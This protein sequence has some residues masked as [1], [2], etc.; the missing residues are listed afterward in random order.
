MVPTSLAL[1]M[2]TYPP[3]KRST[4]IRLWAAVGGVAAALGPVVGGLLVTI[5]WRWVFLINL[6]IGIVTVLVGRR[7]LTKSP[8]RLAGRLPD[9]FGALILLAAIGLLSLGIVK[10]P[11]WGWLSASVF[12]C[13]GVGVALIWVFLLRS[14]HHPSPIVAMHLWRIRSY[15][16]AAVASLLFSVA[17]AAM[18]LSAVLWMQDAWQWSGLLTGFAIAPGPAMLPILAV[19]AAPLARKVGPGVLAAVGSLALAGGVYWWTRSVDVDTSYLTTMLPGI[20]LSGIGV[21]L[22]LPTLISS[23][24]S[25]V[26][27]PW[28]AT[29]SAVITMVRQIGFVLG[30][31]IFIGVLGVPQT[32]VEL[33]SDFVVAWDVTAASAVLAAASSLLMEIWLRRGHQTLGRHRSSR[34]T[35]SATSAKCE[36]CG[37]LRAD[38]S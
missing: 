2:G 1:L 29:G 12:G 33:H 28:F 18:L 5:S 16:A 13:I 26:P 3:E 38:V 4:A 14:A 25:Q 31:S 6:P 8:V 34:V 30:V 19:A 24:L 21:G 36:K 22:A 23:G 10:A 15:S 27:P 37:Q 11:E 7:V 35:G 20:L 17:F 32:P 9:L